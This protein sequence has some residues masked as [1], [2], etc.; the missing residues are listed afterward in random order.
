MIYY[1]VMEL[2]W[3]RTKEWRRV[4][5]TDSLIKARKWIRLMGEFNADYRIDKITVED[6]ENE[7]DNS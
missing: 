1:E 4:Y 7:T 2:A 3:W 6:D 5:V